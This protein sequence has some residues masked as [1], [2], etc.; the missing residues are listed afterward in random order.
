MSRFVCASYSLVSTL[1]VR[2][3]RCVRVCFLF[4][5]LFPASAVFCGR[6]YGSALQ[7]QRATAFPPDMQMSRQWVGPGAPLSAVFNS[8]AAALQY[9]VKGFLSSQSHF[10]PEYG[11]NTLFECINMLSF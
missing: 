4:S 11:T 1:Y 3:R 8:F 5:A 10:F 6:G 7:Q 2:Q 9:S